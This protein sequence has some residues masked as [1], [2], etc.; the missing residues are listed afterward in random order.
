[1][2]ACDMT[3]Q[4]EQ[5]LVALLVNFY[6]SP[7]HAYDINCTFFDE[8]KSNYVEILLAVKSNSIPLRLMYPWYENQRH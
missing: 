8:I 1:M 5:S 6:V 7:K 2:T 4:L 3:H